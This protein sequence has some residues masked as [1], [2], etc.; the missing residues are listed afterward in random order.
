VISA[1][2]IGELTAA[3]EAMSAAIASRPDFGRK[4][5]FVLWDTDRR[6]EL[7]PNGT[8]PPEPVRLKRVARSREADRRPVN[9]ACA[10]SR[11]GRRALDPMTPN[12]HAFTIRL[13]RAHET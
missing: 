7:T 10:S 13:R 3:R 12:S 1:A 8:R 4:L 2:N 11:A 6:R 5:S 9:D